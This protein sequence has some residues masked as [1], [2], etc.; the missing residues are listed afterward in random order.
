MNDTIQDIVSMIVLHLRNTNQN[1]LVDIIKGAEYSLEF[2]EHDNWGAGKD[3]YRLQFSLSFTDFSKC[4]EKK[5]EY[6][7]IIYDALISFYKDDH[8]VITGIDIV[9]K[10]ERFID[11]AAIEPNYSK[12]NVITLLNTEKDYLIK[13][14]TGELQIKGTSVN[15][16][17][18]TLHS[19][20]YTLLKQLGVNHVN[21]YS[22]LW[23]WYNDYKKQNL[24]SYQ[25]RR[26][27][28]N[29]L[30]KPLLEILIQSQNNS[31]N[32]KTMTEKPSL[33]T[34]SQFLKKNKGFDC[35]F[36]H[37]SVNVQDT[38]GQGGNGIV[39][40]GTLQNYDVAIKFLIEYSSK[41]LERFKAE[42]LN[43][44]IVRNKLCNIIN[45]IFYD[46]LNANGAIFPYIIM[47]ICP[48]SLKKKKHNTDNI[49]FDETMKLFNFLCDALDS[50][51][52]QDIIHR[53]L[54]PDNILIDNEDNFIISDFGIA[55]FSEKYPIQG[56]TKKG[57]RLANF[58]F[59]APEQI[60]GGNITY[61]TDIYALFQIIYWFVFNE[62]NRGT[63]GKHL[64]DVFHNSNAK[65]LDQLLYKGISNSP[66]DRYQNISEIRTALKNMQIETK[67]I[68]PF[69]DMHIF[70][71][72]IRSTIPEFFNKITYTNNRDD[73]NSVLLKIKSAKTN[74]PFEFNTGTSNNTIEN[75]EIIDNGNVLINDHELCISGMWGCLS[76]DTY[77]DILILETLPVK[78]YIINDQEEWAVAVLENSDMIPVREIESGFVRYHGKVVPT[79]EL[80]IQERYIYPEN[81]HERYYAIGAFAHCSIIQKNDCY[82]DALQ[83]KENL[84]QDDIKTFREHISR[85]KSK[86]IHMYL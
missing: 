57:E 80:K 74:R 52:K 45:Y 16:D 54:K 28:I 30:Y 75:I 69:D 42:Y 77:N 41:K 2:E 1:E 70:S 79:N 39:Y 12:E 9:S 11:W 37:I 29:E 53:D 66:E 34:L 5:K 85:N 73:I 40:K 72:I 10:I 22:D 82:L 48:L 3:F 58:E 23:A 35:S 43:I 19:T 25:K 8:F 46:E 27:F 61:A 14:A 18:K 86:E 84:T 65:Y 44:S 15:N 7:Q 64:Y 20:L 33:H 47:E 21:S 17:Y 76:N 51:E 50:F 55:H 36:G 26:D 4:I 13:V 31:I 60:N 62:T 63:G 67:E 83:R 71:R 78:P 49:T 38:L 81:L 68:N 24:D 32:K 6:E 56:L 59:A